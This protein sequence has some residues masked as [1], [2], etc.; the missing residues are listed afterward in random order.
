MPDLGPAETAVDY[1]QVY[2]SRQTGNAVVRLDKRS[3]GVKRPVEASDFAPIHALLGFAKCRGLQAPDLYRHERP[4]RPGIDRQYVD[5]VPAELDVARDDAPSERGKEV[6]CR[7]L[8]RVP[9]PLTLRPHARPAS[10]RAITGRL[11]A[12]YLQ[13]SG[14]SDC[15][16]HER[17]LPADVRRD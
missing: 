6:C 10:A 16:A 5:L 2:P 7:R 14:D 17:R 3:E 12:A 11:S 1:H 4:R 13:K 8:G 9:A 15:G